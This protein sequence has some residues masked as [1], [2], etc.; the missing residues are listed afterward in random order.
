MAVALYARVSTGRQVKA[1]LSIPDQLEQMRAWCRDQGLTIAREYVEGGLTATDD[2]RPE[3]RRMMDDATIRPAPYEAILVH[4]RSRFFRD[5]ISC[6][7]YERQLKKVGARLISITQLTADDANGR[8]LNI[9][10]SAFDGH[11]SEENAKHTSR[12]MKA[13]ARRGFFNGSHAPYRL[14][15]C[16]YGCRRQPG[17]NAQEADPRGRGGISGA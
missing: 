15:G 5:A 10:I 3:F 7:L 6:G 8:L 14:Q 12:A 16:G 9:V 17:K 13:N 11:F 2:N 1:D 4:S